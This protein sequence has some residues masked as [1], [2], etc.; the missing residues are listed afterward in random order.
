MPAK[1]I[2]NKAKNALI[3]SFI[4][5]SL[6]IPNLTLRIVCNS[7]I[8]N[9]SERVGVPPRVGSEYGHF[10]VLGDGVRGRL[11]HGVT[12]ESL[13]IHRGPKYADQAVTV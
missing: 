3:S 11:T 4:A 13:A 2:T 7:V 5:L 6:K 9:L 10:E 8:G 1:A 12:I